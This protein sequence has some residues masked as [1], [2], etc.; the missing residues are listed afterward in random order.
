MK[1]ELLSTEYQV[2]RMED[3]CP[4]FVTI[5]SIKEDLKELPKGR[6]NCHHNRS[7]SIP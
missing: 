5:D 7:L 6:W 3:N 4:P 1:I 2:K